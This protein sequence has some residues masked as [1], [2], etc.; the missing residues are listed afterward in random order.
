M[1]IDE[2]IDKLARALRQ[3]SAEHGRPKSWA[4]GE[5]RAE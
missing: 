2:A 3:A 5:L 4:P 1:T